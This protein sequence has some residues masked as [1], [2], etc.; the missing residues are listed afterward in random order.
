MHNHLLLGNLFSVDVV[1]YCHVHSTDVLPDPDNCAKFYK[2][3]N[4]VSKVTGQAEE[5]P[6]PDL[7]ST[8]TKSCE[9]FTTVNC[10]TRKE[11][12]SPCM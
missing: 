6:Y 8:S 11:P 2:C 5:C 3:S 12:Q 7:F 10:G 9:A 1:E 4:L